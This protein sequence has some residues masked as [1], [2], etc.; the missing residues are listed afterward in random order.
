VLKQSN[1]RTSTSPHQGSAWDGM[2]NVCPV[3][4]GSILKCFLSHGIGWSWN[5]PSHPMKLHTRGILLRKKVQ[6][7]NMQKKIDFITNH[8]TTI[9][10]FRIEFYFSLVSLKYAKDIYIKTITYIVLNKKKEFLLKMFVQWNGMGSSLK[11]NHSDNRIRSWFYRN[12]Y[13]TNEILWR[14]GLRT[15]IPNS[16]VGFNRILVSESDWIPSYNLTSLYYWVKMLIRTQ[17]R[18]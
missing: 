18:K 15:D 1:K 4:N 16:S 14:S 6:V 8:W 11:E 12:F 5:F 7:P 2:K 3:W 10:F 17:I 13:K 9:M